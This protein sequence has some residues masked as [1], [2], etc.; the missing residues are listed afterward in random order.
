MALD[1]DYAAELAYLLKPYNI[2]WI[3]EHLMPDDYAGHA[4]LGKKFESMRGCASFAT[5]EHEYTQFGFQQL[6]NSGVE[7]LQPDVM[8]MG[9][10]VANKPSET[11][12]FA[13]WGA[14]KLGANLPY[15]PTIDPD[16]NTRGAGKLFY[17]GTNGGLAVQGGVS[18]FRSVFAGSLGSAVG[19]GGLNLFKIRSSQAEATSGWRAG[20]YFLRLADKGSPKLNWAQN[21][22]AL[23]QEMRALRPIFDSFKT[24][25][26]QL[27]PSRSGSFLNA[28]RHLLMD[29]GWIY[30][31]KRG[32]WVPPTH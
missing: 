23:R 20:D 11:Y 14:N 7:L 2:R 12:N 18:A 16:E 27:I 28:E 9:A 13:A 32:A 22:G 24:A 21:S 19:A 17:Y 29:R 31:A 30:N 10:A 5:G 3:E 6:I 1:V 15:A 25:S 26:G 4:K 8:W